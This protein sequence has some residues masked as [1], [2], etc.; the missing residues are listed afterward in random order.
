MANIYMKDPKCFVFNLVRAATA[1][2][3]LVSS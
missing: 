3:F 1:A 2:M